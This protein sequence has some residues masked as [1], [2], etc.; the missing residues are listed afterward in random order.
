MGGWCLAGA[1]RAPPRGAERLGAE[2][3]A[4]A[5]V[6]AA[7]TDARVRVTS[8]AGPYHVDMRAL[9]ARLR[10]RELAAGAR[11]RRAVVSAVT[12][13]RDFVRVE[14][15]GVA[16]RARLAVDASG[17]SAAL[18]TRV[19]ALDALCPAV[20]RADLCAAAES[21]YAV[22]DPRALARWL[23]AHGTEPGGSVALL[24]VAGGYSTLTIFTEPE[25]REVGVLAGTI[26]AGGAPT[27]AEVVRRFTAR[28]PWI[29]ERLYGGQGGIP[30]RYPY[31]TL[32]RARV[33][34]IGDSACQ[35]YGTHGSGV[36]MGLVAARLL[37]DAVIGSLDP[38]AES[39]LETYTREFHR[40]H[41]GSLAAADAFRRYSQS[42][43]RHAIAALIER[44]VLD[45]RGIAAGMEQ[46][47]PAVDAQWLAGRARSL[48]GA[49]GERARLAHGRADARAR[50][51][52]Q[53]DPAPRARTPRRAPRA[54]GA[55]ARRPDSAAA[56]GGAR[57]GRRG[58]C[59][60]GRREVVRRGRRTLAPLTRRITRRR[61]RARLATPR[62]ARAT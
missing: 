20:D 62:S 53:G 50:G 46:R 37:A 58:H 47:L 40:R 22:R 49:G 57:R 7:G 28:A 38:G 21:Q 25:L 29:G 27:G 31:P 26:P 18:R 8:A 52:G 33:A 17:L 34:L 2:T 24:G 11:E 45:V 56:S 23:A 44:R 35:V 19:A 12:I 3:H 60:I 59:L 15:D 42:L 55:P 5:I 4:P 10:E 61:S 48:A 51:A 30:L 41:G 39:V 32:G 54:R 1:G 13:E 6:G 14:A 9:V 36:G 43:D 16:L